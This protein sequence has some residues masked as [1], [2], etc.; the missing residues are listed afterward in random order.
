MPPGRSSPRCPGVVHLPSPCGRG[1]G[2]EG[3]E[4]ATEVTRERPATS[5]VGPPKVAGIAS[6]RA[7]AHSRRRASPLSLWERGGGEGSVSASEGLATT[8]LVASPPGAAP[9]AA[10]DPP[11]GAAGPAGAARTTRWRRPPRALP[12][13]QAQRH[14]RDVAHPEQ[15]RADRRRQHD[16]LRRVVP[17]GLAVR[18]RHADLQVPWPP[19]RRHRPVQGL[20]D[21]RGEERGL[22]ARAGHDHPPP[23][24]AP[25]HLTA[26]PHP[27]VAGPPVGVLQEPVAIDGCGGAAPRRWPRPPPRRTP[28]RPAAAAS[29]PRAAAPR[30]TSRRRRSRGRRHEPGTIAAES[31]MARVSARGPHR[32][33]IDRP[34][35]RRPNAG[36]RDAGRPRAHRERHVLRG[37]GELRQLDRLSHGK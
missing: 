3:S 34:D 32:R 26:P 23:D 21:G 14:R 25:R 17:P 22:G 31:K 36:A 11:P 7:S 12:T 18:T 10:P 37:P 9:A 24:R 28:R 29:P 13:G 16:Q 33:Q 1:A 20:V 30:P 5:R 6:R 35:A 8:C 4:Q 19:P 2:G 15:P 27:A